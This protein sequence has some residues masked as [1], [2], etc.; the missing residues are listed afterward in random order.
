M[1]SSSDVLALINQLEHRFPVA[2]WRAGDIDLWPVYRLRLYMNV[3]LSMLAAETAPTGTLTRR[4][5]Q[6]RQLARGMWAP[7]AAA[8]RDRDMNASM[9]APAGAVC[10]SD[11]VSFTPVD[12]RWYDRIMD[13]VVESLGRRGIRMLKLTPGSNIYLPRT[14]PSVLVQPQIDRSLAMPGRSSPALDLPAFESFQEAA[15]AF[16]AHVPTRA[17]LNG[18]ARRLNDLANAFARIMVRVGAGHA[19]VNTYY[20]LQGFAFVLAARRCGIP[21]ADLQHGLQ[22]DHHG[23]Y[24][25]WI[26]VPTEGY[27][28]LPTEFWVW[29]EEERRAIDAWRAGTSNHAPRI[30]GN[31][32]RDRWFDDSDPMVARDVARARTMRVD[33]RPQALVSLAWG[34]ASEETD[35]IIRAARLTGDRMAWWWR[36]HPVEA[37]L[38]RDFAARLTSAG[39]DGGT[40][41]FATTHPLYAL[42]RGSDVTL[43]HSSTVM[44]EAAVFGVR[45]V[46]TADYG[47]ELHANLLDSGMALHAT[48]DEAIAN[49]ALR[50]AAQQKR[51]A[52]RPNE[53]GIDSA[54]DAWLGTQRQETAA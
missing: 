30:T 5:R 2:R 19:F 14:H 22:G 20:S 34:L 12:G 50:L 43:S 8:W 4:A 28:T 9:S 45:S 53:C 10:L 41:E 44:Q 1:K 37:H 23:A 25:S 31:F 26:N 40:V 18:Q 54:V 38:W 17:W 3:T 7:R 46:V 6:L 24:G 47:T 39:L 32:W 52:S 13:P 16:G 48:T 29:S 36:L 49:A 27:S 15:A 33:G 51:T 42:V 35:K 11:G 21:C